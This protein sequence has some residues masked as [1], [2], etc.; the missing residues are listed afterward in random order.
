MGTEFGELRGKQGSEANF[1]V[2]FAWKEALR[3]IANT[4][5]EEM[6]SYG[7]AVYQKVLEKG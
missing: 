7:K 2:D 4:V 1:R 5:P 3:L 6:F